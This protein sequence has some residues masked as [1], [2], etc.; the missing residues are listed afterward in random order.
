L[1]DIARSG[2]EILTSDTD[3]LVM[4]ARA[5]RKELVITPVST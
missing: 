3:D 5:A 4:L 2:D 1:V